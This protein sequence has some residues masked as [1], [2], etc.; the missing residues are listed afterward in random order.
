MTWQRT[1]DEAALNLAVNAYATRAPFLTS[2]GGGLAWH[3]SGNIGGI[4]Q[5]AG[6]E[7][8][9]AQGFDETPPS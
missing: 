6:F 3:P 5:A 7:A 4:H 1:L 8:I 2:N 9:A